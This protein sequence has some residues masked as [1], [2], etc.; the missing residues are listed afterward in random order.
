MAIKK[1]M[2]LSSGLAV[3]ECYWRIDEMHINDMASHCLVTVNGYASQDDRAAGK[4]PIP[5]LR[6]TFVVPPELVQQVMAQAT[7]QEHPT[8]RDAIKAACYEWL[9][10]CSEFD[11]GSTI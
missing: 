10:T 5:E 1:A 2:M 9:M 8:V 11:G 7:D 3:P 4:P 6:W